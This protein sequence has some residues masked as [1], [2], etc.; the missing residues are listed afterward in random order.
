MEEPFSGDS[1]TFFGMVCFHFIATRLK[2]WSEECDIQQEY[3]RRERCLARRRLKG[4]KINKYDKSIPTRRKEITTFDHYFDAILGKGTTCH[5]SGR[6]CP[7]AWLDKKHVLYDKRTMYAVD[8]LRTFWDA[9]RF[10]S[11]TCVTWLGIEHKQAK[12][13]LVYP[14]AWVRVFAEIEDWIRAAR[15]ISPVP[16]SN[17]RFRSCGTVCFPEEEAWIYHFTSRLGHPLIIMNLWKQHPRF[18]QCAALRLTL[19]LEPWQEFSPFQATKLVPR[20]QLEVSPATVQSFPIIWEQVVRT[21]SRVWEVAPPMSK[22]FWDVPNRLTQKWSPAIT[23]RHFLAW[24][25]AT[26]A[27]AKE[28]TYTHTSWLGGTFVINTSLLPLFYWLS[29]KRPDRATA[30]SEIR[31][32]SLS[33]KMMFLIDFDLPHAQYIDPLYICPIRGCSI[34][35]VAERMIRRVCMLDIEDTSCPTP[36]DVTYLSDAS[37][38][39]GPGLVKNSFRLFYYFIV[40]EPPDR[41]VLNQAINLELKQVFGSLFDVPHLKEGVCDVSIQG[42]RHG[43]RC[44]FHDRYSKKDGQRM[45]AHNRPFLPFAALHRNQVLTDPVD[46]ETFCFFTSRLSPSATPSRIEY[47]VLEKGYPLLFQAP[48]PPPPATLK[49]ARDAEW[50]ALLW[51]SP[52]PVT[53]PILAKPA[54]ESEASRAR[55]RL[56]LFRSGHSTYNGSHGYTEKIAAR[57]LA[58]YFLNST[59]SGIRLFL[60]EENHFGSQ[61]ELDEISLN[62]TAL[63]FRVVCKPRTA[64]CLNKSKQ[65]GFHARYFHQSNRSKATFQAN[66]VILGTMDEG[67]S[68]ETLWLSLAKS[69][70]IELLRRDPKL[71][72]FFPSIEETLGMNAPL[73]SA[74]SLVAKK[75]ESMSYVPSYLTD[76]Q[77]SDSW[78]ASLPWTMPSFLPSESYNHSSSSSSSSS[79]SSSLSLSASPP[80]S[81]ESVSVSSS[82]AF[83]VTIVSSPTHPQEIHSPP[84]PR[85]DV[86]HEPLESSDV[87][88]HVSSPSPIS[89]DICKPKRA[90]LTPLFIPPPIP[91]KRMFQSASRKEIPIFPAKQPLGPIRRTFQPCAPV[92]ALMGKRVSGSTGKCVVWKRQCLT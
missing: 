21:R 91:Q 25:R 18:R 77:S 49:E 11:S 20:I 2:A 19:Q 10:H 7:H 64:H 61:V 60:S 37:G 31:P 82:S 23:L 78:W 15:F 62:Y 40:L 4:Y 73:S 45:K 26:P 5:P 70:L 42:T 41:V 85:Q 68:S 52:V 16:V 47:S 55:L 57:E 53:G 9:S 1:L 14:E 69:P 32:P 27:E 88:M 86:V 6:S 43:T 33:E 28:R 92:N 46:F 44:L 56:D 84:P 12:E 58:S 67:C 24:C 87:D 89:M 8:S 35:S 63:R 29:W 48:A 34:A 3:E 38:P 79:A 54:E 65:H 13:S 75:D 80:I 51:T 71:K 17:W 81:F 66:G 72:P 90:P 36:M 39:S 50:E 22:P 59:L 76:S 30:L 83:D 74:S